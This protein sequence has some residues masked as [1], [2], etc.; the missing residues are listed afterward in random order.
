MHLD[1][2]NRL[3][4]QLDRGRTRDRIGDIETRNENTTLRRACSFDVQISVRTTHDAGKQR[5][6]VLKLLID[7][8]RLAQR[9]LC[10]NR[11]CG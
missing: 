1:R 3:Q 7:E 4:R 5:Q 8:R 10:D 9:F 2:V 11:R 6:R